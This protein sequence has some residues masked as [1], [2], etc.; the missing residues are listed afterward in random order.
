M[1]GSVF[2]PVPEIIP[3]ARAGTGYVG[4]GETPGAIVGRTL[5]QSGTLQQASFGSTTIVHPSGRLL[6]DGHLK[7]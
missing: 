6:N 1:L 7:E 3:G 4:L 5:G 2:G